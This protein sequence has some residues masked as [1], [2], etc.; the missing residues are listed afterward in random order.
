MLGFSFQGMRR[1]YSGPFHNQNKNQ[2]KTKPKKTT[3][4]KGNNSWESL[5][6]REV[7]FLISTADL[8]GLTPGSI[9]LVLITK[10]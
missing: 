6:F 10:T 9:Y 1:Q 2:T 4:S 8:G 7:L 5:G 3:V